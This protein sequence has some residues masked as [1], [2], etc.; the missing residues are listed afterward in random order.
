MALE[1]RTEGELEEALD[2]AAAANDLVFIEVHT[3]R[4][5][6]PEAL[7]NAGRSMAKINQLRSEEDLVGTLRP[8]QC[9][10]E[11]NERIR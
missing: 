1:A 2:K 11:E 10:R 8:D 4:W 3:G 6:C 7:R 9:F 5:D